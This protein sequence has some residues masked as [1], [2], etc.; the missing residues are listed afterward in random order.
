MQKGKSVFRIQLAK[1]LIFANEKS[2][3]SK[4]IK[5]HRQHARKQGKVILK[6]YEATV[7]PPKNKIRKKKEREKRISKFLS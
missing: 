3:K 6:Q 5:I 4:N 7:I 1:T 2:R